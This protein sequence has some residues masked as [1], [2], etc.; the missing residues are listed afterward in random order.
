MGG[1]MRGWSHM[2]GYGG[3]GGMFMGLIWII[4]VGVIVYFV[5]DRSKKAGRTNDPLGVSPLEILKKR[6]AS[7]EIT[8]EEYDQLKSD[9]EG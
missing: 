1:P 2:T 4:I 8:K 7:G 9:I 3:Y 6:Y 5:L